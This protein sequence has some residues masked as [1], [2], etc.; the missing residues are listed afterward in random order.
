MDNKVAALTIVRAGTAITFLWIGILIFRAPEAWG[1]LLQP[2]AAG[3][4]PI[5]LR[6]AML[7]TAAL[8][9]AI[10]LFLLIDKYVA[11]AAAIGFAH[12][13]IVLAVIGINETTV[14]DIGLAAATLA[15]A[16]GWWP[17]R[18]L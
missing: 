1:G 13:L 9:I 7:G 17:S 11:Y 10:G 4:L 2:W 3:I 6:E 5:P 15:L 12:L 14:R 16:V 18:R 8:D